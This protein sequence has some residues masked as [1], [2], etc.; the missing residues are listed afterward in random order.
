MSSNIVIHL[1]SLEK[2]IFYSGGLEGLV[3]LQHPQPQLQLPVTP[4]ISLLNIY[5][6]ETRRVPMK[7]LVVD[8]GGKSQ[9]TF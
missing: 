8:C 1:L 6:F 9:E 5:V 7:L 2:L 3:V 4:L